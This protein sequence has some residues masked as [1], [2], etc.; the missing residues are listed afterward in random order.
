MV[1]YSKLF[2]SGNSVAVC[3][4]KEALEQLELKSGDYIKAEVIDGK[5]IISK[6][7]E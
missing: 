4:A 5:I 7:E 1:K 3:F 2:K 6:V